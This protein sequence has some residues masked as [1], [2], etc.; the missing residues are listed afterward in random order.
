MF[1]PRFYL[2]HDDSQEKSFT[3]FGSVQLGPRA[4][5]NSV[6]FEERQFWSKSIACVVSKGRMTAL[7]FSGLEKELIIIT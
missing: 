1:L 6:S 5:H 2:F 7:A 4:I 3:Y